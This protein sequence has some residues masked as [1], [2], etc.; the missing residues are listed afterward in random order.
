LGDGTSST[1]S[2]PVH[3]Y[4]QPGQY[5]LRLTVLSN[6]GCSSNKTFPAWAMVRQLPT[7]DFKYILSEGTQNNNVVDFR[8]LSYSNIVQSFWQFG[9]FGKAI[10][11]TSISL[12]DTAT[13]P[14]K[15][16]VMDQYGCVNQ[17]QRS[18]FTSGPLL[19]FMPNAFTP[20]HDMLNDGF[21][22]Q[23][24]VNAQT[25]NYQIFNRWGELLFETYSV[26][27]T[28]DGKYQGEN[29]PQDVYAYSIQLTDM[30]G[31]FKS[32]RGSFTLIR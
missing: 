3:T 12:Q 24:V 9:R 29:C 23:G 18:I 22:P 4:S 8:N 32:Y 26:Q 7:A 27:D 15:L 21:G 19:L 13:I 17:I 1:D 20:N 16:W 30:F 10:H 5:N 25:Y 6:N 11:D 31:R 2:C 14:V 28:W